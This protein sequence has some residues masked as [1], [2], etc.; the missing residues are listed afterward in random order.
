M[1]AAP[2]SATLAM[3][4]PVVGLSVSKRVPS[5]GSTHSLLMN[6]RVCPMAG[7]AK[8][9][10]VARVAWAIGIPPCVRLLE[11]LLYIT[12][13]KI[14]ETLQARQKRL[15]SRLSCRSK[16]DHLAFTRTNSTVQALGCRD[17]N[18]RAIPIAVFG[19][20][21]PSVRRDTCQAASQTLGACSPS[22][23]LY[24][25]YLF[26]HDRAAQGC[27]QVQGA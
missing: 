26:E 19:S 2:R 20:R 21:R 5:C 25:W 6:R 12:I 11:C 16:D 23:L 7:T 22:V 3:T 15:G 17:G 9:S 8:R 24:S 4:S 18:A 14:S 1:S 10:V 13:C 27:R